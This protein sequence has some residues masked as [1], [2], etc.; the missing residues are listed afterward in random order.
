M[1][2]EVV[3][4]GEDAL[5][6]FRQE[7]VWRAQRAAGAVSK[8][9]PVQALPGCTLHPVLDVGQG[10]AGLASDLAQGDTTSG[11]EHQFAALSL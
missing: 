2:A 1:L 6:H 8:L 11:Q 10:Q 3:A 5:D 9:H 4:Q 7:G